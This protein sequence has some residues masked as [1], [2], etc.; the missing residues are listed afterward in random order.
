VDGV[1]L[2]IEASAVLVRPRDSDT[3]ENARL[4]L[5]FTHHVSDVAH[6]GASGVVLNC[7]PHDV[8]A[9]IASRLLKPLGNP[10]QNGTKFFCTADVWSLPKTAPGWSR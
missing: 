1:K 7:Q 6:D 9:L 5:A 2:D 10:A 4:S 3:R 8:P